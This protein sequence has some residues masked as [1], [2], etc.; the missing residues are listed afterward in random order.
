MP[1]V[2]KEVQSPGMEV[3]CSECDA[4]VHCEDSDW[5]RVTYYKHDRKKINE[6]IDCP[7]CFCRIYRWDDRY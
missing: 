5:E 2:L 3:Q 1:I 6:A 7:N 4:V